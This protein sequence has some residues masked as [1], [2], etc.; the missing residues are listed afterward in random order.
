MNNFIKLINALLKFWYLL[1][2]LLWKKQKNEN[3][4]EYYYHHCTNGKTTRYATSLC[5]RR[6]FEQRSL[7]SIRRFYIS[8]DRLAEIQK[9]LNNN[10]EDKITF[11]E[12]KRK[13]LMVKRKRLSNRKQN[14][15]DCLIL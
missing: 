2:I 7:S 12:A 8:E 1:K 13:E 14:M 9:A 15:Y 3:I 4:H 11:Y 10:H 6:R 5:D